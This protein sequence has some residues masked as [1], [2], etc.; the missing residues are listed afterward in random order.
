MIGKAF[1]TRQKMR[2]AVVGMAMLLSSCATPAGPREGSVPETPV[3]WRSAA[4]EE[5]L[6]IASLRQWWEQFEDPVLSRLVEE[7]LAGSPD[8]RTALSRIEESRA[9]VGVQRSALFPVLNAGVSAQTSHTENRVTD[10]TT[11]MDRF[12]AS[13]D[14]SWEVDLWGKNSRLTAAAR[15][16][17]AQSVE[18]YHAAQVSLA[19]EVVLAYV[20]LRTAE[21]RLAVV[22]ENLK[23]REE[24]VQITHWR[25]QSGQTSAL[26]ARQATSTLEQARASIPVLLQN[27]QQGRNRLSLLLGKMPGA[28]EESLWE[29]GALPLVPS[30]LVVGIPA[31]TLRQR[32]DVRTAERAI[33]AARARTESANRQRLP[34]LQLSGSLGVDALDVGNLVTSPTNI[35]RSLLARLTGPIFDAGRIQQNIHIQS[36]QEQQAWIAYE[37]AV[38]SALTEVENALIA[39]QYTLQRMEVL[40]RAI[41]AAE[42]VAELAAWKYQ[43]GEVDLLVVL[44]AQ[45]TLLSLKEQEVST[46]EEEVT[47]C[48]QLYKSLGGGWTPLE[49]Q[50][51]RI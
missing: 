40:K 12:A 22:R 42:E 31:E 25:E 13:L 43:A 3:Q 32:P 38:L 20:S 51:N 8:M 48:V 2:I 6:E 21:V 29:T 41:V 49:G 45:R 7:A 18:S 44:E 24:T 23:L 14:A 10:T 19:A 15:A 1:K 5:G 27:I 50:K 4:T 35:T 28:L 33:E 17:L 47:A 11:S 36:E 16:D 37:K 39:S 34:S 9:R 26:E 30:N 46:R